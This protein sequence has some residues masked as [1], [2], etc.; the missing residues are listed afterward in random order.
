MRPLPRPAQFEALVVW[1]LVARQQ[2]E[3]KTKRRIKKIG[4]TLAEARWDW[5]QKRWRMSTMKEIKMFP[6]ITGGD[7][8]DRGDNDKERGSDERMKEKKSYVDDDDSDVEDYITQLLRDRPPPMMTYAGGPGNIATAPKATPGTLQGAAGA[9]QTEGGQL[10][11]VVQS[12]T[13]T[14]TRAEAQVQVPTPSSPGI[15][16]NVPTLETVSNLVVPQAKPI[17]DVLQCAKY[18]SDEF[19]LKQKKLKEK[20]MVMQIK[21]AQSGLQGELVPSMP[22]QQ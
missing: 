8:S 10:A 2:H 4:K 5:E 20:A 12:T 1:E 22:P 21:A 15:Y 3:L 9:V 17:D 13:V 16:P 6:S 11:G 7:D 14:E 18:C 19:E